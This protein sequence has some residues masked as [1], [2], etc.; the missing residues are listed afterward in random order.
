MPFNPG[1]VEE[2]A[3][4]RIALREELAPHF[5][6]PRRIVWEVGC[7]HGHF[8]ASYATQHPD[9]FCIGV[10][11]S[12]DRIAR[13]NRKSSRA[14]L[15]NCRFVQCE[16]REFLRA[17]SPKTMLEEIWLLFPDPWPKKRH[18]KNRIIQHEFLEAIA[19]RAGQG[20]RLFFRTDHSQYFAAALEVFVASK[21]WFITPGAAWP[22]ELPT[23][24]QVRAQSYQSLAAV[25]TG[26]PATPGETTAPGLPLPAGPTSVA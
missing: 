6:A 3:R 25:R 10:D 7:G 5:A 13:A 2:I 26:H 1:F 9:R 8:L 14:Q 20:A 16:A 19:A 15:S 23:V 17:L 11:L 12:R 18:H 24:F 21:T 22:Q 4:R